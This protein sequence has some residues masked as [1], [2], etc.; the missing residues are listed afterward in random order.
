MRA[1]RAFALRL[2]GLFAGSRR[3]REIADELA[4]HLQLHIDDNIRAGMSPDAARRDA[5]I[6]LGGV[7]ATKERYR[8][9][10]GLPMLDTLRQDLVYAARVLRRNPGFTCTAILTLALGVGVN[11]AIFSVVDAVL[12]RPLPFP[13]ADRLVMI[14]ATNIKSGDTTDVASH[15]DYLDWSKARGFERMGAFAGGGMTVTGTGDA[16]FVSGLR[17]SPTLFDTV[18]VNPALGRGFTL[19][20]QNPGAPRVV[21]LSDGFWKRQYGGAAG[22][23]GRELRVNDAPYTIVGVMPPGFHVSSNAAEQLYIPLTIDP[24]RNH[25]FL[26]VIGRLRPGVTTAEAQAEMQVVTGQIARAFPKSNE[27]VRATV[28]PLLDA[29]AATVRT[30]L[31]ILIGVVALVLLIACTNVASLTLARGAA[32]QR[33]LAVRAALGAGRGRIARQLLTESLLLALAGGGVGLVVGS[34][35]ARGL[36]AIL[37]TSFPV[38]RIDGTHTDAWVLG[39]TLVLALATGVIFGVVPALSSAS[40]DLTDAMREASRST[41]GARAPRLRSGL[42][43]LETALALVLLAGAGVLLKTFATLRSTPPGFQSDHL[44]AADLRL[45]QPRFA[46]QADRERFYDA[47]LSRLRGTPGVRSAAFVADLPLNGGSDGLGFHIVGR[48][49]PAPGKSFEAGFNVASADY[50]RTMEIPVRAGREFTDADRAGTP[51]VIVVN[52][53]AAKRFWPGQSPLGQRI[54][55]PRE[56]RVPTANHERDGD[57]D[58]DAVILTVVGVTGD[59]RH[60]GL[61]V[62]PRPEIFVNAMQSELPWPWSVLAVRTVADPESLIA[63]VKETAR[64]ADRNV[65]LIRINTMDRILTRATAA[66]RVYATLLGAFASLALALAAVGLYGLV[67]YTVSQRT[68]EMGIRLALGA[69]RTEIVQ[70]VLRGGLALAGIGAVIGVAVAFATTRLLSGLTAGVQPSDPLTFAIVTVVL[71]AAAMIASYLPARRAAR[72]DPMTA[73]RTE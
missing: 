54:A 71:M 12:L 31:F 16:E 25:G 42:V 30:G 36:V 10:R 41:T 6:A 37:S 49:D 1:L 33:E 67:S 40:P 35:T 72:V 28:I 15:P 27:N 58:A 9:Q 32:R 18:G 11:T 59:V 73:L 3:D 57:S 2:G 70:L 34:W 60:E 8:D 17:V 47:V 62:P 23:I 64:A 50:F 55:L 22:A 44:L 63:T 66:P 14:F 56:T 52:E 19:D 51:G 7:E 5:L 61:A 21:V 65:P 4:S 69:E 53:T 46:L 39:F 48:P 45:P 38:P 20:E 29:M 68:H 13:A 24:S 43:I 26:R